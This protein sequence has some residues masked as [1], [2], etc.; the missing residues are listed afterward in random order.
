MTWLRLLPAVLLVALIGVFALLLLGP[1]RV[2]DDPLVGQPVPNVVLEALPGH[3]GF[4][5]A[6]VEGPY[7]LNIWGSWCPPCRAEHPM[8]RSLAG[9]G[10]PIYGIAWR[11]EPDDAAAF[12]TELGD[13][14][15]GIVLD[16]R[17]SMV[18]E[19]GA[20]GAPETFV[21]DREG[22]I[23]ARYAGPLTAQAIER[24]IWPLWEEVSNAN[25]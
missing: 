25:R 9:E 13:P 23:R 20:T 15:A 18:I 17:G 24:E 5:P 11:D 16:P 21:V 22:I 12:I 2:A 7:L 1:D 19:L 3:D 4:D 10:V 6:A 8:L 14:F